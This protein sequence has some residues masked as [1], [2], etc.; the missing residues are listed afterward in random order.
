MCH[1][2]QSILGMSNYGYF[3]ISKPRSR[4]QALTMSYDYLSQQIVGAIFTQN[5]V[6][7]VKSGFEQNV[8]QNHTLS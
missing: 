8:T 1:I 2:W 5:S 7:M 6:C 4:D 3:S